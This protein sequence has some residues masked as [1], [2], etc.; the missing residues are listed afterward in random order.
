MITYRGLV[1][2]FG[3]P[4]DSGMG[5]TEGLALVDRVRECPDVFLPVFPPNAM[6]LGRWLD[7]QKFYI[8]MRWPKGF[9]HRQL[10]EMKV[11]VSGPD[12]IEHVAQPVDW[13][14]GVLARI[15]DLSPGLMSACGVT[16]D[17]GI[18]VVKLYN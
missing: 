7:P 12:G 10:R 6:A 4:H 1:S 3:G 16:T 17:E 18:V 9:S 11:T 14:P 8:A 15:A 2:E 13:G 5:A